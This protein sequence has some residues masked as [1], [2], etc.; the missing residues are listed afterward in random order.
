MTM[1]DNLK[2]VLL[3]SVLSV[4]QWA[5]AAQPGVGAQSSMVVA[6][7]SAAML[8]LPEITTIVFP[9]NADTKPVVNK[10]MGV[11]ISGHGTCK[12]MVLNWG[13][14]T[15]KVFHDVKLPTSYTPHTYTSVGPKHLYVSSPNCK[16]VAATDITVSP[17]QILQKN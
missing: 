14:G 12:T 8:A 9:T 11:W 2:L 4:A 5:H 15:S 3:A 7:P 17:A 1:I 10:E 16:G 6:P 13:D